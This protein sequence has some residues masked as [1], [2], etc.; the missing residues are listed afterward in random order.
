M[1]KSFPDLPLR[2]NSQQ[3]IPLNIGY[4]SNLKENTES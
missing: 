4:N 3:Q 2:T 1:R